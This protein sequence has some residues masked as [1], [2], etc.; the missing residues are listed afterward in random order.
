MGGGGGG[1]WSVGEEFDVGYAAIWAG[2]GARS[3]G[4]V[5]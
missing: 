4:E 2:P 5:D 3:F 1:G